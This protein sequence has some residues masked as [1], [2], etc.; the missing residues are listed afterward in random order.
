MSLVQH[1]F[2]ED[3][4]QKTG[5]GSALVY[6]CDRCNDITVGPVSHKQHFAHSVTL[7]IP[8]HMNIYSSVP[9]N[10]GALF[11]LLD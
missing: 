10:S 3:S 8:C 2:I 5:I 7:H 1:C 4:I 9:D 6:I 11:V